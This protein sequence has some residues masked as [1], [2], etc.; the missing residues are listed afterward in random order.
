MADSF[1]HDKHFVRCGCNTGLRF[2]RNLPSTFD[3]YPVEAKRN[4]S[5]RIALFLSFWCAVFV[6]HTWT[7]AKGLC[8][9]FFKSRWVN[10]TRGKSV[11]CLFSCLILKPPCGAVPSFLIELLPMLSPLILVAVTYIGER[12]IYTMKHG[13]LCSK[14]VTS[15]KFKCCC[16]SNVYSIFPV[17]M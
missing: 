4:P 7:A 11:C 3:I 12:A 14:L 13:V 16:S 9:V 2:L 8:A 17:L 5:K 15:W 6:K 1:I 10:V